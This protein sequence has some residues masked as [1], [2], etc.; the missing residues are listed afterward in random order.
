MSESGIAFEKFLSKYSHKGPDPFAA[1]E[2]LYTEQVQLMI[3]NKKWK[4]L[5]RFCDQSMYLTQSV[6]FVG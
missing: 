3:E 1:T 4:Q 2:M 5:T 6:T